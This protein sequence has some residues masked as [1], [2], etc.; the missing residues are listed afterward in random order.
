MA[1]AK[2]VVE[3]KPCYYV[4][5]DGKTGTILSITNEK[6][7]NLEVGLEVDTDAVCRFFSGEWKFSDYIVSYKK[8]PDGSTIKDIIPKIDQDY[9]FRSNVFEWI[10]EN[11]I[12][13]PEVLVEWDFPKKVWR[14]KLN[15]AQQEEILLSKIMFFVTLSTDFDFLI[16]TIVIDTTDLI[17]NVVEVPFDSK[18]E[19]DIKQISISSKLS[20]R[21][22]K[23]RII[24]E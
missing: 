24:N 17:N 19:L 1:R 23:L 22:Y 13:D 7:P 12:E 15:V 6:N 14:F 16:R 18:K 3:S 4:Y 9:G 10:S 8:L 11:E 5:Y 20:F 2:K 21:T